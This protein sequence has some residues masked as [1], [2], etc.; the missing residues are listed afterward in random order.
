MWW[1]IIVILIIFAAVLYWIVSFY[2]SQVVTRKV[3]NQEE[4]Y[5]D[6][7][8]RGLFDK[9]KY[10]E[11]KEEEAYIISA[12]GLKLRGI[13]IEGDRNVNRTM[14]FVHGITVGIPCSIKYIDIFMKRGWNILM[15][16]QR[17]HGKS[18][19]RYSTYGYYEKKDLDLWVQWVVKRN[20]KVGVL[21]LHGESMGAATVLQYLPMNRFA[22]FAIADCSY[23]NLNELL[24]YHMNKDYH[25]PAF[26]FVNLTSLW[27]RVRAGFSF[28]D[29]SPIDA[30][31]NTS[32]PV[33]FIHGS[34]DTFVPCHMSRDMYNARK[35]NKRIYI[36]EGA[37]HACSIEMDRERYEKEVM[38]F[39]NEVLN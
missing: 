37:D 16:D 7:A 20:G 39:V 35:E 24:K 10:E 38:S 17:R 12:D 21:G 2:F 32:L 8:A 19:G 1:I 22:R 18:E 28:S 9:E 4:L 26:P 14:I 29:V 11:L 3:C 6:Q 27:A 31:K 36:A 5:E 34:C 25:L 30:V 15:Y 13:Y 33:L 23:S